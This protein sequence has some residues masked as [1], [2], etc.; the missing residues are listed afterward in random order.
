MKS[1]TTF[2]LVDASRADRLWLLDEDNLYARGAV[3]VLASGE[4]RVAMHGRRFG[5][6][7]ITLGFPP[8]GAGGLR[9][10]TL[11]LTPEI[12]NGIGRMHATFGSGD[13]FDLRIDAF[14]QNYV[15]LVSESFDALR[16]S[17]G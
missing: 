8:R 13:P 4:D 7:R 12:P 16:A 9:T 5:A 15:S 2:V 17:Q 1:G 3:H 6:R 10:M 11:W 14:G